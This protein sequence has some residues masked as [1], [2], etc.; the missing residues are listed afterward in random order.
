MLV[1]SPDGNRA[2]LGRS[3]KSTPGVCVCVRCHIGGGRGV[4]AGREGRADAAAKAV[5]KYRWPGRRNRLLTMQYQ[6]V[7]SAT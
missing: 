4:W 6:L 2:L 5:I 1:E 3:A 7:D